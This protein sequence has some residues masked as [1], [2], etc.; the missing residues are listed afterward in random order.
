MTFFAS[1]NIFVSRMCV[2]IVKSARSGMG[3]S[4]YVKKMAQKLEELRGTGPYIK[5]VPIHGPKVTPDHVLELL[6]SCIDSHACNSSIIHFD[7]SPKVSLQW[8]GVEPLFDV[9]CPSHS[10]H[11]AWEGM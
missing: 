9:F 11:R 7:V 3:K 8:C 10:L 1:V 2:R 4:L 5:T 6:Q